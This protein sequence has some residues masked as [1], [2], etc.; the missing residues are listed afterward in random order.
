LQQSLLLLAPFTA[1]IPPASALDAYRRHLHEQDSIPVSGDTDLGRAVGEA[2]RVGLA[3]PHPQLDGWV[4]V[5]PVFPYFLRSRLR[6]HH[7]LHD[8]I[9][10]AHYQLYAE[11]GAELQSLL[12]DPANA[13][14]RATGRA[15]TQ[16]EYANLTTALAWALSTGQPAMDLIAPLEEY[17]DQAKQQTARRRLLDD[18]ITSYPADASDTRRQELAQLHHLAGM[19]AQDQRRFDDAEASYRQA[20]DIKLEFGDR[21]SAAG[22]YHQL[23]RVAQEQRRFADAEASYQQA[24]DIFLESGDRHS[25]AITY[26]QLGNVAL[27]QRRFADAEASHRQALDIKLELG[28]RHSAA[29]T[30]GQ[31]GNVA[32]EQRRFADA[33]ASYQ[34]ALDIFLESGDGHAAARTYHQLG[35]IA[36]EQR[37][38]DDAE[39]SYR[40]ALDIY[41]GTDPR[42]ASTTATQ[43]GVLLAETGRH[44][45]AA[46]I[47]I[48]AAVGWHQLTGDWDARDVQYLKRQRTILGQDEFGRLA[49]AKVPQDLRQSLD[50]ELD[51]AGES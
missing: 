16:A 15:A 40:Q 49:D 19:T 6:D 18:A 14:R 8:A 22:T 51:D 44:D 38:L 5:Q 3:A 17:L 11:L 10:Q 4:Q 13:H 41:L 20:L 43:L 42:Q 9:V 12:T 26:G 48:E 50:S 46:V 1:V 39:A 47:L 2:V 28:D 24:L 35:M 23:G 33:E 36:H 21:H 7:G 25:A 45:E 32:L 34:Q 29:S 27:E 31:L 30:Y 37:R